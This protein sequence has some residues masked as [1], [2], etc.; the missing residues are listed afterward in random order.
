[1]K[2]ILVLALLFVFATTTTTKADWSNSFNDLYGNSHQDAI[3]YLAE[4]G[5]VKGYEVQAYG[6]TYYDFKPN[7]H[8][9][10]AQVAIML[11]RALQLQNKPFD[12]PRF[13]DVKKTHSAYKEIAIATH[14][15]FF[16]DGGAF[17]PN[18]PMTRERVA[19][20]LTRGFQLTGTSDVTFSDVPKSSP[21]YTAIQALAANNITIGSN[22]KFSPKQKVNRG[23]FASFLTRAIVPAARPTNETYRQHD[24]LVPTK[25]GTT[26]VY[27]ASFDGESSRYVLDST[28][29][30][31]KDEDHTVTRVDGFNGPS[32]YEDHY[33]LLEYYEDANRFG[34]SINLSYAKHYFTLNYP[35]KANSTKTFTYYNTMLEEK[36]TEMAKVVTTNGIFKAG[37]TI[38]FDVLVVESRRDESY[39]PTTFYIAKDVGLLAVIPGMGYYELTDYYH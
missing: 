16:K 11:V 2:K 12:A 14:Y 13:T 15:G 9:T 36:V 29:D 19:E 32:Y 1:M 37:D 4:E 3:Y 6:T 26:Y 30:F 23:Q 35:I 5:I 28:Y 8:V 27:S 25:Y 38:Y 34:F 7:N 22:G 18:E 17:K 24:G 21:Y 31:T 39:D 20:T 33:S 10:N